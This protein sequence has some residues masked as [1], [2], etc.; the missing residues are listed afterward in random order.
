MD[1]INRFTYNF[2]DEQIC[3]NKSRAALLCQ[4]FNVLPVTDYAAQSLSVAA[5][6]FKIGGSLFFAVKK[7]SF[8]RHNCA[9]R[10]S[11]GYAVNVCTND[12]EYAALKNSFAENARVIVACSEGGFSDGQ[13]NALSSL[14]AYSLSFMA[15]NEEFDIEDNYASYKSGEAASEENNLI[16]INSCRGIR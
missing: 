9:V 15:D 10:Y 11:L 2:Y 7:S 8:I 6:R 14:S 4:K 16:S 13:I 12:F 3:K 5:I 1:S